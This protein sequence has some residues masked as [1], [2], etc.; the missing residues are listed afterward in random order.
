MPRSFVVLAVASLLAARALAQATVAPELQA[1]LAAAGPGQRVPAVLVMADQ[2]S[3][4]RVRTATRG[5][6]GRELRAAVAGLLRRH[7]AASQAAPRALLDEAAAR[8]RAARVRELWLGNAL[9]FEAEPAVIAALAAVPGVDRLRL[10][11]APDP[12]ALQDAAPAG[13]AAPAPPPGATGA[14]APEPNL[15]ALQAPDLWALGYDGAGVLVANIDFGTNWSHP[16][17]VNRIWTNPGEVAGN[18]VDDDGNGFTDD[19]HGWNFVGDNGDVTNTADQHGTHTAGI[20][21]GDGSSGGKLTGMAPGARLLVCRVSSEATFW[22]AQQYALDM[23][24]DC[25]SSSVSFKWAFV[26]KPDYHMHRQVCDMELAA[27]VAHANSIGNQGLQTIT[28]PIPFNVAAPGNCPAP[29]RHP[30]Q[31]AGGESGVLG[32]G[33]ILQVTDALYT[34]SGKGPSAWEPMQ[35]YDILYPWPQLPQYWDYPFGGFIGGLPGLVKPDLMAYTDV[36]TTT[37]TGGYTQF[38]GTSAATPHAG[39]ALALL[40]QVQ[41][42]A[43]PRHLAGALLLTTTELASPGLDNTTGAGKLQAADAARRLLVLGRFDDVAPALG[44]TVQ[45]DLFAPPRELVY[46]FLS[47]GLHAGSGD[48]NLDSPFYLLGPFPVGASG[49]TGVPVAIP[50]LPPLAGVRVWLQFGCQN[51]LSGWGSGPFLSVPEWITPGL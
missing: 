29:F 24:A 32:C 31:A 48:W 12:A 35:L 2:P 13:P 26:P 34:A 33:A 49:A 4:E 50:V 45:L 36:K 8:G 15:A 43:L 11:V 16:D 14:V 40:A 25:V 17:L 5:L 1:A 19:L 9:V 10:D 42:Q 37:G 38:G 18:G 51:H 44:E 27:G 20:L 6:H 23:G 21:V 41:P 30:G 22:L 3:L 28:Y 47:A 46:G 7:A 39:G